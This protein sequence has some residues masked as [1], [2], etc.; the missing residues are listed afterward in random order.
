MSEPD[1]WQAILERLAEPWPAK[2]IGRRRVKGKREKIDYVPHWAIRQRLSIVCPDWSMSLVFHTTPERLIAVCSLRIMG[3]ER[4]AA[5]EFPWPEK[6]DGWT[7]TDSA[8]AQALKRACRLYG[9]PFTGDE[10]DS[11]GQNPELPAPAAEPQRAITTAPI[12][13]GQIEQD[14]D[15]KDAQLI[16]IADSWEK[17]QQAWEWAEQL[18]GPGGG[19]L[20]LAREDVEQ[21]YDAQVAA[22][23]DTLPQGTVLDIRKIGREEYYK[24]VRLLHRQFARACVAL[25]EGT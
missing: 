10:L 8:V 9:M 6:P 16:D 1:R 5:S 15:P 2:M 19:P 17:K 25:R 22:Y 4:T 3:R 7:A 14:L 23:H 11:E 21:F 20:F 12:A 13:D 18:A 24:H